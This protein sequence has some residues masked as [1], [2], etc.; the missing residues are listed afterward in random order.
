MGWIARSLVLT[1]VLVAACEPDSPPPGPNAAQTK[2]AETGDPVFA[3]AEPGK[4]RLM[5]AGAEIVGL[6]GDTG[7][8][9]WTADGSRFVA[10]VG[11]RQLVSVDV[12]TGSVAKAECAC[13]DIAIAAGKVFASADYGATELSV[14][15]AVTLEP[16]APLALDGGAS[17]D[18]R[19]G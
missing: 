6:D 4:L 1:L 7:P 17:G 15:D 16:Q 11:E 9:E 12:R 2:P 8:S 19:C 3:Y 14:Y 5:R 13:Y 18:R 10:R